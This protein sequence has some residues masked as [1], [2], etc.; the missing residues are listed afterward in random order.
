MAREFELKFRASARQM[1]AILEDHAGF[2]E[3]SMETAYF[4]TPENTLSQRKWTLR[5]RRENG[6]KIIAGRPIRL[7]RG[8]LPHTRLSAL[9]RVL[10]PSIK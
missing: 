5:Q 10:S 9:K 1:T 6:Q 4:D 7:R 3:I 8:T 2:R